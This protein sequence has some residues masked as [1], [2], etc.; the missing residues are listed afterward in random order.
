MKRKGKRW[1]SLFLMGA[2]IISVLSGCGGNADK[3]P[4]EAEA[5][6]TPAISV[7]GL[8]VNGLSDPLGI[9]TETPLF[10]WR[11]ESVQTGAKQSAYQI[12][13]TDPEGTVMWDSG[14]VED[15][16]SQNI[17][18]A[19]ET[20]NPRTL[21]VWNLTVTDGEGTELP[22][23]EAFFETSLMSGHMDFNYGAWSGAQWIGSP[24]M[25]FD[26]ATANYFSLDMTVQIPDGSTKAGIIFGADDYRLKNSAMNIWGSQSGGYFCYEIDAADAAAP[27]LNIYVVGMPAFGQDAENDA[28][29]ADFTVEIPAGVIANVHDPIAV[30]I[31]TLTNINQVTCA[32]N[33]V[34]VDENRQLNPLGN[35]HDYNSFPNAANIGFAVPAGGQAV[36]TEI[37]LH[38]P[39]AY[40]E[41][42]EVGDLFGAHV[43]ATYAIFEGLDGITVDGETIRADGGA[44]GI[45]A[46][47][48]PSYGSAPM[49]RT[50]FDAGEQEIAS[51]RLYMAAQGVYEA[52][53]NGEKVS[54]DWFAP[55]SDEYATIMPYQIYD[56]TEF[57]QSGANAIGVQLAEGWW[58]GYQTYTVGNYGYYGAKQALLAKLD[59]TYADGSTETVV[60]DTDNWN[61]YNHGPRQQF[62]RR[63]L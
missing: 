5:P 21:Y 3:S 15:A 44:N 51:A 12:T 45:L 47:A 16:A 11:M 13:V 53:V 4:Q 17:A 10:G 58:S 61:V 40:E 14:K 31:N 22:A 52:F 35:T 37:A 2:L 20:L 63:T 32:I 38:Y 24:E 59:V 46:C 27:K 34:T 33:G 9:E 41:A 48:D 25:Y 7:A 50:E 60:T 1:L 54:E 30:N 23:Q 28:A 49:L 6:E 42:Y 26:A 18:Y 43:G 36:Y 62:P 8:T 56:V 57:L 39:G 19:G 55:G 29:E